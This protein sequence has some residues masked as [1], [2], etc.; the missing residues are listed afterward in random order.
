MVGVVVVVMIGMLLLMSGVCW[1]RC[2]VRAM[3]M[4][5]T[6]GICGA[7]RPNALPSRIPPAVPQSGMAADGEEK[8]MRMGMLCRG[9]CRRSG[10]EHT[11]PERANN[12]LSG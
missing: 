6:V 7:R 1:R 12:A 8:G 10:Q 3:R 5:A 9:G 2:D 11:G 4:V